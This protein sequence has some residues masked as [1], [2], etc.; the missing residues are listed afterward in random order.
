MRRRTLP[1]AMGLL[2]AATACGPA[3]VVVKMEQTVDN[4]DGTTA[5]RP[6]PNVVVDILPFDRDQVFDSLQKAY[7]TPEPEIPAELLAA[8]D[9]VRQA[10]EEW[11][12]DQDRW[13][14]LRDTLQKINAA[15]KQYSR[16]EGKYLA[17]YK[18][19]NDLDA[20]Y[21]KIDKEMNEAFKRY[22]AK[23]K[24]TLHESD[25]IR[26]LRS[27]WS[28]QAF[29]DVNK[30]FAAKLQAAGVQVVEDTTNAQG[31][32]GQ[33]LQVKPGK[34]WVS[35]HFELPYSELYWNVPIEV[36]RGK[37]FQVTLDN[38]NAKERPKL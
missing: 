38:K 27:N 36:K 9:S 3:Q 37:P 5:Q 31:I 29:A 8:R 34:Y 26:V 1:F 2:L 15:M 10:Y 32:A 19:F 13:N 11:Q 30:V 22:D 6:I 28:D 17:L 25:S 14:T 21:G 35:A 7:A 16:G 12:H 18:D 4:P 24:A 33:H 23:Q 20:E